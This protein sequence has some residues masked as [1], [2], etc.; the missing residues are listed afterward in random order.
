[1]ET[2]IVK[3]YEVSLY[4]DKHDQIYVAEAVKLKGCVTHGATEE[5]A[6][7]EMK[8][9]IQEHIKLSEQQKLPLEAAMAIY[10]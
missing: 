5:E 4:F 10:C 6:I 2:V 9:A 1:M 8:I 3:G 7:S